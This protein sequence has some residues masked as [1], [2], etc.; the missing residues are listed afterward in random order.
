M[1]TLRTRKGLF[2]SLFPGKPA[3]PSTRAN[4][5]AFKAGAKAFKKSGGSSTYLQD[6]VFLSLKNEARIKA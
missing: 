6:A 3:K 2:L 1:A 4:S 5:V